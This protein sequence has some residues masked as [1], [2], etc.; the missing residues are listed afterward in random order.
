MK[1]AW[2]RTLAAGLIVAGVAVAGRG[3]EKESAKPL[4]GAA[5]TAAS[6]TTASAPTT[7]AASTRP[8]QTPVLS[9]TTVEHKDVPYGGPDATLDVMDIYSPA[10]AVK[11][12][13]VLFVHGG[14][15]TKGDKREI[16]CKPKFLNEHGIVFV[17]MNY[18]LSPKDHHPA[19]VDDVASAV[20]WCRAHIAEYGG[21]P[22]KIVLMGHSAG[23]HLATMVALSPEPLKKAGLKPSDILGVVAWS[24]G[25]YDLVDRAKGTGLYPPLIRENFGDSEDAQRAASPLTYAKNA[26]GGP[27]FLFASVDDEKS[28]NSRDASQGMVDAINAAGGTAKSILLVGKAH[29]TANHELG[30]EGDKTGLQLLEFIT[31]LVR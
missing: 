28:K 11:A 25:M 27:A 22:G 10:K 26:K 4:A 31:G 18:R 2:L 15:W 20:A 12:P 14:E 13:V 5:G 23:C 8:A 1:V 3:Q 19:Q 21:D 17:S 16:S 6:A 24:G 9:E 7:R 30:A 29:F